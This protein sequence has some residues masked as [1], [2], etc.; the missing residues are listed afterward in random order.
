MTDYWLIVR[1]IMSCTLHNINVDTNIDNRSESECSKQIL[2]Q[3]R[4]NP[5][6]QGT[7]ISNSLCRSL[8]NDH[9]HHYSNENELLRE[10]DEV[11]SFHCAI[12]H[13]SAHH[14]QHT[15]SSHPTIAT[16]IPFCNAANDVQ[17]TAAGISCPHSTRRNLKITKMTYWTAKFASIALAWDIP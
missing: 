6:R 17:L 11:M 5:Q 1:I 3:N 8:C 12:S 4:W 7:G 16:E 2:F 9:S 10:S 13:V 14:L 15:R